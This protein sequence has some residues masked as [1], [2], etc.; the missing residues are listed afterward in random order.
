MFTVHCDSRDLQAGRLKCSVAANWVARR[1]EQGQWCG[2]CDTQRPF[3]RTMC[4]WAFDME[5]VASSP[6]ASNLIA[7]ASNLLEMASDRQIQANQSPKVAPAEGSP[8]DGP[9]RPS[10]PSRQLCHLCRAPL[11]R[12]L[13]SAASKDATRGSWPY[14]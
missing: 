8:S 7:I 5:Q 14:Y 13:F 12:F 6:E 11:G 10:S 9:A 2:W 4:I 1:D 3:R